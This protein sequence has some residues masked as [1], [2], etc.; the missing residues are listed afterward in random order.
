MIARA[1]P[2]SDGWTIREARPSDAEKLARCIDAS[3]RKYKKRISDLPP[4]SEGIEE[5]IRNNH[6]WVVDVANEIVGGVVIVKGADHVLLANIAVDPRHSGRGLGRALID[7]AE[8]VCRELGLR[9]LRLTTH[10]AMPENIGFYEHLGW[11]KNGGS[12]NKIT[13]VKNIRRGHSQR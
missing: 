10:A 6:V 12:G 2:G 13:M 11:R 8:Q 7:Q 3:Y 5:D 9:V 1:T 4:V